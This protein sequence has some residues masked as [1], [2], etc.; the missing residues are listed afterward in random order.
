MPKRVTKAVVKKSSKP[1]VKK[2]KTKQN[3]RAK[4]K[5]CGLGLIQYRILRAID[6][7]GKADGLS[8]QDIQ[9]HTGYYSILTAT[10]R[11]T[12]E[13]SLCDKKLCKEQLF[14]VDGRDK[15]FF[16]ITKRGQQ[17]LAKA[18]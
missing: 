11:P 15:L 14:D 3:E 4:A 8:Y 12:H 2:A 10:M 5:L 9:K 6:R 16:K 1:S 7:Y 18:N 13:G 17:A